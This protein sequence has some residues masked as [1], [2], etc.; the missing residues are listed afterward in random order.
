MRVSSWYENIEKTPAKSGYYVAFKGLSMGDNETGMDYYYWDNVKKQW[1][2]S[3]VGHS[4]SA[5][6]VYWTD[7]DP[8]SWY[9][10]E[11]I[12]RHKRQNILEKVTVKEAWEDV[13]EAVKKYET[14]KALANEY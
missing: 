6:V 7:A 13:V 1:A 11:S 5:N 2:D 9:N 8:A 14:I 12:P 4:N 10:E 3:S